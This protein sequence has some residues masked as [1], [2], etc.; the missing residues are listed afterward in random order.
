[1]VRVRR[2]RFD[3]CA[4]ETTLRQYQPHMCSGPEGVKSV[5][6]D[7]EQER[8]SFLEGMSSIRV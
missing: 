6:K 2:L 4:N 1:M 8:E 7:K 5:P 3:S